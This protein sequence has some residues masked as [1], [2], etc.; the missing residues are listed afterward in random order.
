MYSKHHHHHNSTPPSPHQYTSTP[1]SHNHHASI[2]AHQY[3]PSVHHHTST[4]LPHQYT[5]TPVHHHHHTSTPAHQYTITAPVHHHHTSTPAHHHHHTSKRTNHYYLAMCERRR[6]FLN[7]NMSSTN[8]FF[9]FYFIV[10]LISTGC[11][12]LLLS[13]TKRTH[14]HFIHFRSKIALRRSVILGKRKPLKWQKKSPTFL[15]T[16][17]FNRKAIYP[18]SLTVLILAS[19]YFERIFF[20]ISQPSQNILL[21][22]ILILFIQLIIL[23]TCGIFLTD[24]Q[25]KFCIPIYYSLSTVENWV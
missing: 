12:L 6:Q 13:F 23:L 24:F 10:N 15:E 3:P 5:S 14:I 19:I 11:Y 22:H 4:P 25:L 16:T 17:N 2:P 18:G 9:F 21:R 20:L 8:F 1:A 7:I